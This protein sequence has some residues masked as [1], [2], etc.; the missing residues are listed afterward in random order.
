MLPLWL[1]IV[2]PIVS[3]LVLVTA[4]V[5][6]WAWRRYR[7]QVIEYVEDG[8]DEGQMARYKV[9]RGRMVPA[10]WNVSL[11]GSMFGLGQFQSLEEDNLTG[12]N[13][14]RSRSPFGIFTGDR[15][16]RNRSLLS[17]T[18]SEKS[19]GFDDNV[20][21]GVTSPTREHNREL[22]ANVD[23]A[24][25]SKVPP[26]KIAPLSRN[27]SFETTE[28]HKR[29]RTK[30][31]KPAAAV[32]RRSSSSRSSNPNPQQALNI[33][34]PVARVLSPIQASPRES[35]HSSQRAK[36]PLSFST[37]LE[38]A[39]RRS[40]GNLRPGSKSLDPRAHG[41]TS[42]SPLA[43]GSSTPEPPKSA[44]EAHSHEDSLQSSWLQS[45]TSLAPRPKPSESSLQLENPNISRGSRPKS[46][47]ARPKTSDATSRS[48]QP[49]SIARP[50]TSGFLTLSDTPPPTPP[51]TDSPTRPK[52]STSVTTTT[53]TTTTTI[54]AQAG[55]LKSPASLPRPVSAVRSNPSLRPTSRPL[56]A[57][58]FAPSDLSST[59]TLGLAQE[60][61]MY[62]VPPPL[63][64][65]DYYPSPLPPLPPPLPPLSLSTTTTAPPPPPPT[66]PHQ[67]HLPSNWSPP[68]SWEKVELPIPPIEPPDE[69]GGGG[70]GGGGG[71]KRSASEGGNGNGGNSTTKPAPMRRN[72]SKLVKKSLM[73]QG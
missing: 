73:R 29:K 23:E 32:P 21:R 4:C 3:I 62:K 52:A 67:Q 10:S 26:A 66:K 14:T 25:L 8:D 51:K 44:P 58:S 65:S 11:T 60:T 49:S 28:N 15:P 16:R 33:K 18:L 27:Q 48:A 45:S 19:K 72:S 68:E 35:P 12:G 38:D 39:N 71:K 36:S 24:F 46:V 57:A 47:S 40:S 63:P 64:N 41:R 54:P 42:V 2:I 34:N 43:M 53:T 22:L 55:P 31:N 30:S 1:I 37:T 56:T 50:K 59:F 6:I 7:Q 5:G 20:N 13:R 17:M 61:P 69:A 70:G 9:R